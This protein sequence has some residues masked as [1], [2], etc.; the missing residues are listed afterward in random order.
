M[1]FK[2]TSNHTGFYS[3]TVE[4][5]IMPL[6]DRVLGLK[7]MPELRKW[8]SIQWKSSDEL[9]NIQQRNLD[10]LITFA[11]SQCPWYRK[12][13]IELTRDAVSSLKKFPVLTKRIINDHLDDLVCGEKGSLLKRMSSGSTGQRTVVF[14]DRLR[15]STAMASQMLL[16][17]W[18]GYKLGAP[19]LQ[20]GMSL[21]RGI[22]KRTKDILLRTD[23]QLAFNLHKASVLSVLKF[24]RGRNDFILG[25]YASGLYSYAKFAEEAGLDD[26]AFRSVISFGDKLFP[27]YRDTIEKQ[28]HTKVFDTY[29]CAEGIVIAGQCEKMNYHIM[30]N[31]V[32]IEIVD[33]VGREVS[34]CEIGNVLLTRLDSFSMPLIRYKLGDL[35]IAGDP[36]AVCSCGRGFPLLGG[37]I[38][39]DTDIVKTRS[40]KRMIVHFF[41]G[42]F[43]HIPEIKQF[44]VV[45]TTLDEI[46]IEFIPTDEFTSETLERVRTIIQD[47]LKEPFGINFIRVDSLEPTRTG[48][49]KFIESRIK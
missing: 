15:H 41:T 31:H 45:Q 24:Y 42:I 20:L 22:V 3:K 32:F 19:I 23:Y 49:P 12:L 5:L 46:D 7:I 25:G 11:I 47:H 4:H 9:S 1:L 8:R 40:G 36:A 17:E 18:A 38:G 44:R 14:T 30:T 29:G 16:W 28:F 10:A 35:A 48:K 27:H 2:K 21:S 39:R 33:D 26:I 6:A 34:P 37:V 43:E 13:G